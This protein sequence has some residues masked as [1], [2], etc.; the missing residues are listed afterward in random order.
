M[1]RTKITVETDRLLVI[2]RRQRFALA[3]CAECAAE[4]RLATA[5]EAAVMVGLSLR[6]LCR[7][8]EEGRLHFRET[9]DGLLWICVNSLPEQ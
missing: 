9:A 7:R 1:K 2:R 4:V 3:W 8:V 6:D 5:E